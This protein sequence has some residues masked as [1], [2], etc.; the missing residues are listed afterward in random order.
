MT[1]KKR[2]ST[3]LFSLTLAAA[4]FAAAVTYAA[5]A[6]ITAVVVYS[7]R[8]QVTRSQ[9]V[10]CKSGKAVF[11]G[12][13]STLHVK[14]LWASLAGGA[15]GEVVGVTHQE[16]ATGPRPEAEALQLKVR[17]LDDQLVALSGQR[18][19]AGA[20][21]TK[22][23]GFRAH[24][25]Q[26]WG[27][28]AAGKTAP[29]RAWDGALDLLQRQAVTAR[30]KARQAE[31]RQRA[32]RRQRAALTRQLALIKKK[33]RRTTVAV[34]A[35]LKCTG[36][37]T[38]QLS[39]V[40]PG[41]TW[42][43]TY[44]LRADPDSGALALSAR[45]AV[46]QGTGE[47]WQGVKLSVSTANLQRKNT[48]PKLRR[49][50]V[51]TRKPRETRKVLAR[52][53]EHRRHLRANKGKKLDASKNAAAANR[54]SGGEAAQPPAQQEQALAL[55]L[56][57]LKKASVPSD[58]RRVVVTLATR[59]L[60]GALA[61][62]TVPKLYPYVYRKIS[63]DNPFSF[64]MLPGAVDLF[65]GRAFIGRAAVK[66]VRAAGE[67]LDF[68]L[69]VQNQLQ[70]DRFVK[71]EKLEGASTFGS[72][73]KLRHRYVIQLGNWTKRAQKV[74]VLENLPVSQNREIKVS[75]GDDATKPTRWN[76]E[77]G[78]LTWEVKVP[79][80]GKKTLV[81][82]YTVSLPKDYEVRGYR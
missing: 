12:L 18:A 72:S 51:S 7:D 48:P 37:R 19:A 74:R 27:L 60:R 22:L 43:M 75:L 38:V 30:R 8:A 24:A 31:R 82:D 3:P 53:F 76:K 69:G 40:V 71:R 29:V 21:Q 39:Y 5:P 50:R 56:S 73:K 55:R 9:R 68:S 63:A 15:G 13:P 47:D 52:R 49:M 67:P 54:L 58:G 23:A 65:R 25:R 14:T 6:P 2:V 64:P 44:E 45:A 35:L 32:L 62:E 11:T 20:V 4:T 70:V 26:V 36:A 77:D 59:K 78:I 1:T 81:L 61:Y 66:A 57:A 28:Q 17:Q 16:E 10:E 33:R 80:R 79:A 34:T 42:Q 46:Q 41:A